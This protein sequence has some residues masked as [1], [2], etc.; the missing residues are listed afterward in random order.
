MTYQCW[1]ILS[2]PTVGCKLAHGQTHGLV[3]QQYVSDGSTLRCHSTPSHESSFPHFAMYLPQSPSDLK[4]QSLVTHPKD[5]PVKLSSPHSQL[6]S[7]HSGASAPCAL[8]LISEP[9]SDT[10]PKQL[11]A[12][13]AHVTTSS[14]TTEADEKACR[15]DGVVTSSEGPCEVQSRRLEGLSGMTIPGGSLSRYQGA[16][17]ADP[18]FRVRV[19]S[20]KSGVVERIVPLNGGL[21]YGG[22]VYG[23]PA[24]KG[25]TE[26]SSESSSSICQ[27]SED[28]GSCT[29][30]DTGGDMEAQ[31]AYRGPL[32]GMAALDE[33]LPIK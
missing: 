1:E 2:G 25:M 8:N 19:P 31:S 13:E 11:V 20:S 26:N 23:S 33:S 29:S 24:I 4:A 22:H 28:S 3:G 9:C 5:I 14:V 6:L 16:M 7:S 12:S 32:T 21:P 10:S 18:G 30:E 17:L 15:S 27:A